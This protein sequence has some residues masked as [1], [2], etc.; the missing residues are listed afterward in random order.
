MGTR[1]FYIHH[2]LLVK[3]GEARGLGGSELEMVLEM[4]LELENMISNII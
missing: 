4:P 1:G 3:V 2:E